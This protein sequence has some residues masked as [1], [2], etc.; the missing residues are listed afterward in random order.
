MIV[1]S[2]Q[3]V[4]EILDETVQAITVLDLNRLKTAEEKISA[5]ARYSI[6][7]G[8]GGIDTMLAKKHLLD[9]ILRNCESNLDS[10]KHL[11]GRNTRDQW[12]H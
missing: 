4:A 3:A 9:L 10:L 7:W 8:K 5:L 2:D 1:T 12:A 6:A 11:H